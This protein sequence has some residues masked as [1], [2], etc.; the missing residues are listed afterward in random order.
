MFPD[1][2]DPLDSQSEIV[3]GPVASKHAVNSDPAREPATGPGLMLDSLESGTRIVVTTK[4]SAYRFVVIDGAQRR[5]TVAG[6]KMFPEST[7]VRIEGATAGAG[8]IRPGWIIVGLR[9]E[10]SIGLKR[11]TTS[12][13]QSVSF[14]GE[15]SAAPAA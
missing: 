5:A 6:G 9:L 12:S 11:I 14:D 7:E 15:P 10:M 1:D 2:I 8:L 4:H 3:E 13:V